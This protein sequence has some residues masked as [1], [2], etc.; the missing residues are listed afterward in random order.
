MDL[1]DKKCV[2][3]EVGGKPMD[4]A[5]AGLYLADLPEWRASSDMKKIS[6]GFIFKDFKDALAFVDKIGEIAEA[7][8]HH[9]D[10]ALGYGKADIEL[11]THAVDGLTAN[12]FIMA[13][14]I[15]KAFSG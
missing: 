15:D 9:P 7:E 14:K 1:S 3:C 6:R 11:S 2:P 4:A 5:E 8:G 13:A 10:I 12:D